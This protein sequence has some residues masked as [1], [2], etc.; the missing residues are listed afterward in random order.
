M[1]FKVQRSL[2]PL[3]EEA[4]IYNQEKSIVYHVPVTDQIR[5]M[6]GDDMKGF[7]NA[8]V[9]KAGRVEF[10]GSKAEWKSW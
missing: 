1:I 6:M 8:E 3:D 4:L 5:E 10:D 7:Y 9:N 2:H